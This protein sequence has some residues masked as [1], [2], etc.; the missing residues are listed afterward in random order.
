MS[1]TATSGIS[2]IGTTDIRIGSNHTSGIG[3]IGTGTM[4]A[5]NSSICDPR[6]SGGGG[7]TVTWAPT[8]TQQ[9]AT[10]IDRIMAKI[11]Q[12][13]LSIANVCV[14]IRE[15]LNFPKIFFFSFMIFKCNLT[16]LTFY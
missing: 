2:N 9:K 6:V 4:T 3:S 14:L 13:R 16:V 8:P 12:A 10:E 7:G 1:A 11:E 15:N 5:V